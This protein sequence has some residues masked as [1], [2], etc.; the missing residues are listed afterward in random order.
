MD[1][2]KFIK[3]L[4]DKKRLRILNLL[5]EN[6]MCVCELCGVLRVS[7]PLISH[8][9]STLKESGMIKS[10]KIGYWS[11]FSL[12]LEGLSELKRNILE[13]VLK[14]FQKDPSAIQ[15]LK[16]YNA[17]KSRPDKTKC[18]SLSKPKICP[19]TRID[20]KSIL[21]GKERI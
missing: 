3:I 13:A 17:C 14:E 11:Y 4:T 18:F 6:E 8:H 16:R 20:I 12:N 10:R 5:R 2:I 1:L 21:E 15:D 7:Q 19:H 9:L